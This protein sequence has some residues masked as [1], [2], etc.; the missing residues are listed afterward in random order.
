MANGLVDVRFFGQHDRAWVPVS[1]CYLL[2][3]DIPTPISKKKKSGFE[4]SMEE[5]AVHI[6][7]IKEQFGH[8]QYAKFRE[9]FDPEQIHGESKMTSVYSDSK[10]LTSTETS[11]L[12]KG[13]M[14]VVVTSAAVKAAGSPLKAAR[15]ALMRKYRTLAVKATP[16]VVDQNGDSTTESTAQIKLDDTDDTKGLGISETKQPI[17][18]MS[19]DTV[20]CEDKQSPEGLSLIDEKVTEKLLSVDEKLPN[21]PTL[22]ENKTAVSLAATEGGSVTKSLTSETDVSEKS[23]TVEKQSENSPSSDIQPAVVQATVLQVKVNSLDTTVEASNST[24]DDGNNDEEAIKRAGSSVNISKDKSEQFS[25]CVSD[26]KVPVPSNTQSRASIITTRRSA[27]RQSLPAS[28]DKTGDGVFTASKVTKVEAIQLNVPKLDKERLPKLDG[29]VI[30]KLAEKANAYE[31][32]DET[33]EESK[34]VS[35]AVL[36]YNPKPEPGKIDNVQMKTLDLKMQK[37]S[38]LNTCTESI[39]KEQLS[40]LTVGNKNHSTSSSSSTDFQSVPQQQKPDATSSS[41]TD[42]IDQFSV[43]LSKTIEQCKAN[44]GIEETGRLE[45]EKVSEISEEESEEDSS[46]EKCEP[47]VN[48][49]RDEGDLSRKSSN[50]NIDNEKLGVV[51][52]LIVKDESVCKLNIS[53]EDSAEG[54]LETSSSE[55]T[56]VQCDV[57][58]DDITGLPSMLLGSPLTKQ[59]TPCK[60]PPVAPPAESHSVDLMKKEPQAEKKFMKCDPQ[61]N[62][63]APIDLSTM[64]HDSS[65]KRSNESMSDSLA[66]EIDEMNSEPEL[67]IDTELQVTSQSMVGDKTTPTNENKS[68]NGASSE[69]KVADQYKLESQFENTN[70]QAAAC[71]RTLSTQVEVSSGTNTPKRARK[72]TSGHPRCLAK[73]MHSEEIQR[74][75]EEQW[76]RRQWEVSTAKQQASS[77]SASQVSALR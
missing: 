23:T 72:S 67:V 36:L 69:Q 38:S 24:T 2:S 74:K 21:K 39:N 35:K 1:Q 34:T 70:Q 62:N 3:E 8:F 51:T 71:L 63:T 55:K 66:T 46:S 43:N 59:H 22:T 65:V 41:T 14:R 7:R 76:R 52:D 18:N 37:L 49:E 50:C 13:K 42:K 75:Q 73:N 44:L 30:E 56:K 54:S 17:K 10:K 6:Q 27:A 26:I 19:A 12:L 47:V 33:E 58:K 40:N 32:T 48:A 11:E 57:V 29:S 5:L 25:P 60:S 31:P 64:A 77:S 45:L 61:S 4:P 20:P 16:S 9:P 15:V 28:M 68:A 53:N